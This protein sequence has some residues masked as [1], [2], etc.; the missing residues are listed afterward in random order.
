VTTDRRFSND[1][2]EAELLTLRQLW[3]EGMSA[4]LI[5]VE[6]GRSRNSV[7][8]KA[9]RLELAPR[10]SHIGRKRGEPLPPPKPRLTLPVVVRGRLRPVQIAALGRRPPA[11]PPSAPPEP[12]QAPPQIVEGCMFISDDGR[13]WRTCG[14][15]CVPNRPYCLPHMRLC[16][17]PPPRSRLGYA[18]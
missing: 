5:G 11:P 9:H 2:S 12:P 17:L 6:L 3:A 14:A 1:W 8:G 16:Y 7:V 4:R 18:A 13:P 15:P 10:P